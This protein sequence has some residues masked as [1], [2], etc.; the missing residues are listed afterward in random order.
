MIRI[1][2]LGDIGSGK[3]FVAK[4]FGYPVFNA[5][6]EVS[7][8]YEKNKNVYQK[9]KK[10]LPEYIYEFPIDK[11]Q[12]SKAILANN[13][14]LKKIIKIVHKEIRN[15]L[16]SFLIKNKKKRFVILDIPL[17][18]ENK[19]NKKKDILVYVE[20]DKIDILRNLKKRKNFNVKILNK[21]KKI[22]LPLDY[23]KRNS[24]FIIKNKFTQKSVKNGV[25]KILKII[26]DER[27]SS[28][29]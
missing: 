8:L 9:F 14:N 2:I 10:I 24:R 6:Y 22:Q 28:R 4:N 17:L 20:S 15:K 19:I 29:Y 5:D 16:Q 12:L 7:K 11:I 25:N 26:K 21:F 13:S 23:K 3:S 1:G 27:S 18:L